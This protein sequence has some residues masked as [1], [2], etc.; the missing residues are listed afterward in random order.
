MGP[1]SSASSRPHTSHRHAGRTH[2]QDPDRRLIE[3]IAGGD[4]AALAILMARHAADL[5][6]AVRGWVGADHAADDVMAE[7]RLAVWTHAARYQPLATVRAWMFGIARNKA[8]QLLRSRSRRLAH[9]RA[10]DLR[11]A[12][13]LVAREPTAGHADP[14][15]V[16]L[17]YPRSSGLGAAFDALPA[18]LQD[19]LRLL[20]DQQMTYA[21]IAAV[22]DL[23]VGTVKRRVFEARERLRDVL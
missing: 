20:F 9:E 6:R 11:Q 21:E 16:L 22:L 1:Q 3:A 15:A 7:V 2:A 10:E 4:Q 13:D 17:G 23:P 19:P 12:P 18:R 14:A 5:G 8:R